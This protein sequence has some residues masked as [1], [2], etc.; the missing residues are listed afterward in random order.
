MTNPLLWC[1][2]EE[3]TLIFLNCHLIYIATQPALL[4]ETIINHMSWLIKKHP[5]ILKYKRSTSTMITPTSS[6]QKLFSTLFSKK[7][8]SDNPKATTLNFSFDESANDWHT[9]EK[10]YSLFSELGYFE[11]VDTKENKN[12]VEFVIPHITS[13]SFTVDKNT[14]KVNGVYGIPVIVSKSK[15]YYCR[16]AKQIELKNVTC[17]LAFFSQ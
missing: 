8:T 7:R 13:L 15:I 4:L 16:H 1:F 2:K 10:E 11:F 9:N 17:D 12:I 5:K 6:S 14:V 3:K